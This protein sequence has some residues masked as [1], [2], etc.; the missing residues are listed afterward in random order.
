MKKTFLITAIL[1]LLSVVFVSSA[2]AQTL[3]PEPYR[4][5][6]GDTLSSIAHDFCTTWQDVYRYNAGYIGDDPNALR[7]GTLIYVIDRCDQNDVYDRGPSQYAMGTVNGSYYTVAAGD[8]LYSISRRFGLNYQVVMEANGLTSTSVL[9][10][11]TQLLIPGLNVGHLTPMVTITYPVDGSAYYSPY[12]ATG[13]GQGLVEGNVVVRLLDA[14]G[15][16]M[17]EQA[18][19]LQGA[20]VATGGAGSWRVQF[21]KIF[22]QPQ[23][24]GSVEA[25]SPETGATAVSYFLFAG[26]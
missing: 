23:V 12:V 21:D 19:V 8:T 13:T 3:D 7:V 15:N 20:D 4:I 24:Y 1:L 6:P 26:W 14:N 10:P 18:T 17:A 9:Y 16:L 5:Q 25:Y 2:A 22:T 11:G